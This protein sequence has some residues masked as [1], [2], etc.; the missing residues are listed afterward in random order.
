MTHTHSL[1]PP[2]FGCR[3]WFF[4]PLGYPSDIYGMSL[5]RPIWLVWSRSNSRLPCITAFIRPCDRRI[6]PLS[7]EM[8]KEMVVIHA[9]Q[10]F[11]A[12]ASDD[13]A[14]FVPAQSHAS[15]P[16]CGGFLPR[17]WLSP[18][19]CSFST[20]SIL[21]T[22]AC[23]CP[24]PA[25]WGFDGLGSACATG[26]CGVA[27]LSMPM[28]V[29]LRVAAMLSPLSAGFAWGLFAVWEVWLSRWS[30]LMRF[31]VLGF[32]LNFPCEGG[33]PLALAA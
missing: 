18:M 14:G 28:W 24:F 27:Q 29:R 16:F 6:A 8:A 15:R 22:S 12:P 1:S 20:L 19:L 17:C 10:R 31:V 2:F 4:G 26:A 33:H 9:V 7:A 32:D 3:D 5:F 30:A 21:V 23:S 13:L 11:H 25:G